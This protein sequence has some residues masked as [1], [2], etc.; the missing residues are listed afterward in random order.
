MARLA[1]G[2][3]AEN[4]G[5]RQAPIPVHDAA[6]LVP[7]LE[8]QHEV[9]VGEL[10]L[11]LLEDAAEVAGHEAAGVDD[12]PVVPA[13]ASPIEQAAHAHQRR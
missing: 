7:P 11:G 9:G 8:T 12:H 10:D 13:R 4:L 5:P 6:A 2:W 3:Q 1:G